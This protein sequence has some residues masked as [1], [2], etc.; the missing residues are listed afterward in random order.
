MSTELSF[1]GRSLA[2]QKCISNLEK[3]SKTD[4]N[5][6][7]YGETGSG[8]DLAALWI[9]L[10]SIRNMFP[11]V[12]INCACLSEHL[13][14]AELFG[15]ARGSFTGA[16]KD[17]EGLLE[18]AGK[19]TVLFDEIG[20]LPSILQAKMLRLIDKRETRRVGETRVRMN[21]AR[22]IFA[23]NK[24]LSREVNEGRFRKDLYY[25][26]NILCVRM[27]PLR[28]RMEDLPGL[29]HVIIKRENS[30]LSRKHDL[31]PQAL[32]KLMSYEY[33]GNVREL[34]NIIVRAMTSSTELLIYPEAIQFEET[35][36]DSARSGAFSQR[37]IRAALDRCHWNKT[38]A[39]KEIGLS[40]RHFYRLLKKHSIMDL[41]NEIRPI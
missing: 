26:I 15:H 24:C 33:P 41:N 6:L 17:E 16:Y 29:A 38:I 9:H 13:F 7:L 19:G 28:E 21:Y 11:F 32:D 30:T 39:A 14:E 12:P 37:K 20:E 25:R 23:T 3:A 27:P 18:S 22:L 35:T 2:M 5:V 31:T 34:E 1:I 40:R 8:K 36:C 4:K 10:T